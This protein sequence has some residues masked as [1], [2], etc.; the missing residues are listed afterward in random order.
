MPQYLSWIEGP[1]PK[2]NVASSS[3]VWGAKHRDF[4]ANHGVFLIF[5]PI[6]QFNAKSF[7]GPQLL[8]AHKT[9]SNIFEIY[10]LGYTTS[11][12]KPTTIIL[13]L[14]QKKGA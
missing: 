5:S 8:K 6:I 4:T 13:L 10:V 11:L 2:R 3:L 9:D 12:V 1:P 14:P 7:C